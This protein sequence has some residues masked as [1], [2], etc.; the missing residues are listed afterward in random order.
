MYQFSACSGRKLLRCPQRRL[1]AGVFLMAGRRA[2]HQSRS[3]NGGFPQA[4][5]I[6]HHSLARSR[7]PPGS[8]A[9]S[10]Y[11]RFDCE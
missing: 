4:G 9:A 2:A 3:I 1:P 6:S 11:P 10:M 8:I 5:D 7:H